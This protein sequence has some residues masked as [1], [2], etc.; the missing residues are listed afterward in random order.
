MPIMSAGMHIPRVLRSKA[1]L[2]RKMI[3]FFTL[4]YRKCIYVKSQRYRGTHSTM[5][6]TDHTCHATA[7]RYPHTR[8]CFTY[9]LIRQHL[10]AAI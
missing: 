1:L 8:F 6:H 2:S 10:I 4:P 3:Q 5:Q 7:F 9:L